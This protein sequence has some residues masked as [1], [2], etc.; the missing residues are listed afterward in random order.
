MIELIILFVLICVAGVGA[1]IF[2]GATIVY[3]VGLL[4]FKLILLPFKLLFALGKGAVLLACVV[5][6]VLFKVFAGLFAV[7]ATCALGFA[8]VWFIARAVRRRS[9]ADSHSFEPCTKPV[10]PISPHVRR[11]HERIQDF[12]KRMQRLEQVLQRS[13]RAEGSR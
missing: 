11:V 8:C 7:L 12:E 6:L 5:A 4:A 3:L 2:A 13:L 10:D 1:L 9:G